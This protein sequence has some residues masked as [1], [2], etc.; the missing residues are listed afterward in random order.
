MNIEKN[1]RVTVT[2]GSYIRRKND[3]GNICF[4][5]DGALVIKGGE[6]K[7]NINIENGGTV[8]ISF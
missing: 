5:V 8:K 3:Y 6:F 2:S 1:V 7:G 4:E